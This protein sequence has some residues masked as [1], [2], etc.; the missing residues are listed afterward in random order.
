MPFV[1]LRMSESDG[2]EKLKVSND[3]IRVFLYASLGVWLV[4]S[5]AFFCTIDLKYAH[6]FFGMATAS[7]YTT[8]LFLTSSVDAAKFR[9]AFKKRASHTKEIQGEVRKWVA[10]NIDKWLAEKP[11]FFNVELVPDDMLPRSVVLSEGGE[12]RRR[13][14]SMSIK[15]FV[16]RS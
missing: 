15:E 5:F 8:N 2:F 6:T 12:S 10:D 14:S 4:M 3:L 7:Q 9:A 11:A 13:R 16:A 1:A